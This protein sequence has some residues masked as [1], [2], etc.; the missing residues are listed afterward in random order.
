M[1]PGDE[2]AV[3]CVIAEPPFAPDVK[4]TEAEPPANK[5]VADPIVGAC[6]TEVGVIEFDAELATEFPYEFVSTT[7]KVYAVP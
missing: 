3:Y 5:S 1:L 6:G 2:V 4:D 7:L